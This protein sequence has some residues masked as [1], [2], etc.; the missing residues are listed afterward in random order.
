MLDCIIRNGKIVDGTG[1]PWYFSDI[2]IKDGLIAKIGDLSGEDAKRII[3]LR[4]AENT[5]LD[6]RNP[7][8]SMII[9]PGLVDAHGH[10]DGTVLTGSKADSMIKQGVV[11]LV[12]GNCGMSVA[13]VNNKN[14]SS[15]TKKM[16]GGIVS[17]E[18]EVTWSTFEEYLDCLDRNGLV[19]NV[20]AMVGHDAIRQAVIG[21]EERTA[22]PQ[23]IKA[24]VR[25]VVEAME[26]G[27]LGVS[28]GLEFPPAR[29]ANMNELRAIVA[30]AV[31]Y[32]RIYA[33]HI[34]N[35]DQF[36]ESAVAETLRIARE[37]GV[38]LQMSH[39]N[40]KTGASKGTWSRVMNMIAQARE[41][42][43]ID[44]TTDGIPYQYGPGSYLALFPD[45]FIKDGIEQA[46][47]KLKD[48]NIRNRL[49]VDCD[50]YWRFIHLG[51]WERVMLSYSKTH[52]DW[53]GKTLAEI[54]AVTKKDA[55]DCFFDIL[56]DD[57]TDAEGLNLIGWNFDEDHVRQQL[58]HPLFMLASDAFV[59]S[60]AEPLASINK[61]PA[62]FGWAARILG[63]YVRQ[64]KVLSLE[65]AIRKMTSFPCQKFG[66]KQRGLLKEGMIADIVV[67]NADTIQELGSPLIPNIYPIGVEY[68]LVGGEVVVDQGQ[69]TGKTVGR[70][71]RMH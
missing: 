67:F 6:L 23:E 13:P 26:A 21:S 68:V 32:N 15:I 38:K 7:Y 69:F 49:R 47:V 1:N 57:G 61:N 37:T 8:P 55:W 20:V 43:G 52:L 50:R 3:D 2:G 65:E 40:F 11:T 34:R 14:R 4:E 24:M 41:Y 56:A 12:M 58:T 45:W 53:V 35:R 5:V 64:E 33:T 48:K 71:L 31:Q 42:E 29:A 51:E 18:K 39:L 25:L 16:L 62:A 27:A 46:V 60:T 36:Y 54:S 22:T 9:A 10:S 66:L 63:R 28:T 70:V 30:V 19:N 17:S 59:A 44:V